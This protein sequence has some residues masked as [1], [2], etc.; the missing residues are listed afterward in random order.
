[1]VWEKIRAQ[2]AVPTA[3]KVTHKPPTTLHNNTL[4]INMGFPADEYL[5]LSVFIYPLRR[6]QPLWKQRSDIF[7]QH[8]L[9][10]GSSSVLLHPLHHRLQTL[11]LYGLGCNSF[12]AIDADNTGMAIFVQVGEITILELPQI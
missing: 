8:A 12:L 10:E 1:M 4:W 5:L 11:V 7:S 9:P 2:S 3:L 6:N